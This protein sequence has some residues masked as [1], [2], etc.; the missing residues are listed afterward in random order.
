MLCGCRMRP[1]IWERCRQNTSAKVNLVSKTPL[2]SFA[3]AF[4]I[5][6]CVG[7]HGLKLDLFRTSSTIQSQ[8]KSKHLGAKFCLD[9]VSCP[10]RCL[11]ILVKPFPLW[12]LNNLVFPLCLPEQN[13]LR[14]CHWKGDIRTRCFFPELSWVQ[15]KV[16]K[17]WLWFHPPSRWLTDQSRQ[18]TPEQ[19]SC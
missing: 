9:A 16:N 2:K 8:H 14:K 6:V 19:S 3:G 1:F 7:G 15:N 12:E 18:Q 5:K 11:C 17:Q 13:V 4:I 10:Q